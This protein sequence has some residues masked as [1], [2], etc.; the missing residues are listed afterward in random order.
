[1]STVFITGA[2]RGI[3]LALAE[4]FASNRFD[5]ILSCDKNY[6][7]LI[8]KSKNFHTQLK[9]NVAVVKYK[10]ENSGFLIE[11]IFEKE[12]S[13]FIS[14]IYKDS[15]NISC[16]ILINNASKAYYGLIQ[17]MSEDD[18]ENLINSNIST[19]FRTTKATL[20]H[21][22]H[23][24]KGLIINI[25]SIW[26]I[27]GASLEV[28]YSG[29]KG[30]INTWTKALAKE[31]EPSNIDVICFAL[32]IVDTD[33]NKHLTVEEKADIIQQLEN[34]KMF[35]SSEIAEKIY[36]KVNSKSYKTGDILIIDNGLIDAF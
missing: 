34:H 5:L 33:M 17:E 10:K 29:T 7:T 13:S 11:K 19:V 30:F 15:N 12:N 9:V 25:S 18:W 2:S 20:P 32:G 28:A 36:S 4:R 24:K 16:D 31:L 8:E 14:N 3:G 22:I 21:M 35:T 1:M 23:I 27:V 6:E 26:G